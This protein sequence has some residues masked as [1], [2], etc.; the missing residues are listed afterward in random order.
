MKMIYKKPELEIILV[1]HQTQLMAGSPNPWADAK[2]NQFGFEES[3]EMK[4]WNDIFS[5]DKMADPW[6]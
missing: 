2:E 6:K 4:E 5:K 3:D 1:Q